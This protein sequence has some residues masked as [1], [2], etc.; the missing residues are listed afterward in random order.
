MLIALR[1]D[2]QCQLT[3][4]SHSNRDAPRTL[5]AMTAAVISAVASLLV[6]IITVLGTRSRHKQERELLDMELKLRAQLP[7]TSPE[8]L[9][10]DE[11]MAFRVGQWHQRMWRSLSLLPITGGAW[12]VGLAA[13]AGWFA[14]TQDTDSL[15]VSLRR[16]AT[17]V[18]PWLGLAALALGTFTFVVE[19]LALMLRPSIERRRQSRSG[20][21]EDEVAVKLSAP[22]PAGQD[23]A[24][25]T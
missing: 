15:L 3:A 13:L 24:E 11:V 17:E 23:E 9:Q 5:V 7:D 6:A 19:A 25:S 2:P 21:A 16:V 14:L 10:L 12:A 4:I 18:L 8:A 1:T 20:S 22:N